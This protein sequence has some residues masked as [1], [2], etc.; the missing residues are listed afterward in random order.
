MSKPIFIVRFPAEHVMQHRER[1]EEASRDLQTKLSDY[2]VLTMMDPL[3][4]SVQFECYNTTDLDT[5]SFEELKQIV[6]N[7]MEDD[8][9]YLND[10]DVTLNDGL[11][12]S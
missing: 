11:E 10:W 4:D 6:S 12:D 9:P 1:F 2:H 3:I 5:K 8:D 7:A